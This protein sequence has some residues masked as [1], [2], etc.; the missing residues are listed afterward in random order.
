M[1]AS[2]GRGLDP[3]GKLGTK[4]CLFHQRDRDDAGAGRIGNGRAADRTSQSAGNDSNNT[5]PADHLACDSARQIN[6]EIARTRPQQEGTEDD[7]QKHIGRRNPRN[8]P[9]HRVIAIDR[10]EGDSLDTQPRKPEDAADKLTPPRDVGQGKDDQNGDDPTGQ[11]PRQLYRAADADGDGDPV[12]RRQ[13][14][15]AIINRVFRCGEPDG[16]GGNSKP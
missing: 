13:L 10:A 14:Y 12:G 2:A 8:R 6:D 4:A 9:E 5:R 15:P 1:T 7:E 11:P 3:A 16:R